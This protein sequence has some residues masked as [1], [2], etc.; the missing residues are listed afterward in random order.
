MASAAVGAVWNVSGGRR[1]H[2]RHGCGTRSG[3]ERRRRRQRRR[4]PR[5]CPRARGL[6]RDGPGA[7]LS[8]SGGDAPDEGV[9][10]MAAP[11]RLGRFGPVE[12]ASFT[13]TRLRKSMPMAGKVGG[14]WRRRGRPR[15]DAGPAAPTG[16]HRRD[17]GTVPTLAAKVGTGTAVPAAPRRLWQ[18]DGPQLPGGP[19]RQL[20]HLL[21][22]ALHYKNFSG[23]SPVSC[24]AGHHLRQRRDE[25]RHLP[26]GD[27]GQRRPDGVRGALRGSSRRSTARQLPVVLRREVN[28][29]MRRRA[30]RPPERSGVTGAR[31]CRARDD[32][33]PVRA[34]SPMRRTHRCTRR[35][36]RSERRA[37]LQRV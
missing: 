31:E 9:R 7:L 37:R 14:R 19:S 35:G 29:R 17:H 12:A 4:R 8:A 6:A 23:T 28:T 32:V 2:L 30:S 33:R 15:P 34:R 1:P 26:R 22:C 11:R 25:L 16:R 3:G 18:Y 10:R 20:R 21:Y 27:D 13:L 36:G 24:P 5:H